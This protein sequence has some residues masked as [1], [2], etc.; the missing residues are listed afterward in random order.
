VSDTAHTA[1]RVVLRPDRRQNED[2]RG[3]FRGGRRASDQPAFA[4][5]ST[6][7]VDQLWEIASDWAP[8]KIYVH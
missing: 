4:L 1:I 2:R 5:S 6:A 3:Q 8:H 7:D